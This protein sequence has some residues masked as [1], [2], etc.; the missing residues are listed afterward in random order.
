[1]FQVQV[2]EL[3]LSINEDKMG[4]SRVETEKSN[5]SRRISQGA[6]TIHMPP[7]PR[8]SFGMMNL[9]FCTVVG[10]MSFLLGNITG[11]HSG[12]NQ[13][14]ALCDRDTAT[15]VA[16]RDRLNRG[17]FGLNYPD[18]KPIFRW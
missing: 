11:M 10:G 4:T 5:I 7:T 3:S 16:D 12:M 14:K 6:K 8:K 17:K 1:L 13:G 15:L 18:E 2:S 9:L